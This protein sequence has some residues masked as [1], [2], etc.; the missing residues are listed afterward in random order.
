MIVRRYVHSP[1]CRISFIKHSFTIRSI[2][3]FKQ[4]QEEGPSQENGIK[5][6]SWK[7]EE[8]EDLFEVSKQEQQNQK[9]P[10]KGK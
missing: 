6:F 8:T 5:A 1:A 7:T 9:N 2:F 3:F 4:K 10:Q